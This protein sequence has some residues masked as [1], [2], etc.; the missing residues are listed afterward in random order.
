MVHA[1]N[2]TELQPT[3]LVLTHKSIGLLYTTNRWSLWMSRS[4][5]PKILGFWPWDRHTQHGPVKSGP[6]S[7]WAASKSV[8]VVLALVRDPVAV[9]LFDS[10]DLVVRPAF[11]SAFEFLH[12]DIQP[13]PG[14]SGK[15]RRS[16]KVA[17]R[18]GQK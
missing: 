4:T 15:L 8:A 5:M 2:R 12:G 3:P 1:Q 6:S 9:H 10:R 11:N 16:V 13:M 18:L 14:E 17:R 7:V